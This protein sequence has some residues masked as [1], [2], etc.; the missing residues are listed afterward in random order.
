MKLHHLRFEGIGPFKDPV[1]LDF[2]AL[3]ASGLF[4]LE[5]ATGSGKSTIIDALVF[6]LYGN[7]AGEGSSGDRIR[8][9]FMPGAKESFV[10]L[11]FEVPDGL[12]RIRRT[13]AYMRPKQRGEGLT[14]HNATAKLWKL[15]SP[16]A[17]D[18]A[19]A[20]TET[21]AQIDPI[22]SRI[23]DVGAQIA[24]IIGLTHDQF[25][26]TVVL[27]QGEFAR[28]LRA[29]T[30]DR[31]KVLE[32]VFGTHLY[33]AIE[34]QFAKARQ[35]ANRDV[36][37]SQARLEAGMER[38]LEA[39][40]VDDARRAQIAEDCAGYG[41]VQVERASAHVKD[42]EAE[43]AAQ[44][45][46][47]AQEESALSA[48]LD[49]A[50][51]RSEKAGALS[52]L[53]ARRRELDA[54]I[55]RRDALAPTAGSARAAL[56]LHEAVEQAFYALRDRDAAAA[57]LAEAR[58]H[59]SADLREHPERWAAAQ[60]KAAAASETSAR[61]AAELEAL[62]TLEK[63]LPRR[64]AA[65]D[66]A[67]TEAAASLR[68]KEAAGTAVAD[69]PRERAVLGER[70]AALAAQ[71]R[72]LDAE[73]A[74]L[75]AAT[76]RVSAARTAHTL[77]GRLTDASAAAGAAITEARA[78]LDHETSLRTRRMNAMAAELALDLSPGDPC[79]VC[80][81]TEHPA[82]ATASSAL[83][84]AEQ[85]AAAERERQAKER[86]ASERERECGVL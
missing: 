30:K 81:A 24:R 33:D 44:K 5:G 56:A 38:V 59:V 25:T 16:D 14:R 7:V 78:A 70:Q 58:A 28:F 65:L 50:V 12:Y 9:H 23:D 40:A 13:P 39:A 61:E 85:I 20:G 45:T 6:A 3:G 46:A 17:L 29:E 63:N 27:P 80:G 72:P 36:A 4:L 69:R 75:A 42:L 31:K 1:F 47:A 18:A 48:A 49:T 71:A 67:R 11:F 76:A 52:A 2:A 19:I 68:A 41:P 26:Q 73:R 53:L 43:A 54:R 82:P 86:A 32:R 79:A 84:T 62:V 57:A 60:A 21:V 77:A 15:A 55:A 34:D 22:A 51:A 64:A 35:A 8:S 83:V 37:A 66:A 74:H 10:D